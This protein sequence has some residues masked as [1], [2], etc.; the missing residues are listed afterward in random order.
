[1][2]IPSILILNR[3]YATF[4]FGKLH[5]ILC[6]LSPPQPTNQ[7]TNQVHSPKVTSNILE[8][9]VAFFPG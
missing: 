6:S 3:G 4:E 5:K 7:P 9:P 2:D 8:V 1:M